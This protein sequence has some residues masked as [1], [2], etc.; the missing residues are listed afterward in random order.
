MKKLVLLFLCMSLAVQGQIVSED[1]SFNHGGCSIKATFSKPA[2]AGPFTTL[3]LVPGSGQND[4][5]GT[6]AMSGGN[7]E[8]LYPD[9]NGK[10]ITPYKD[11]AESLSAAGYAVLRYDELTISCPGFAGAFSYENVFLPAMSGLDYL[12]T[13]N[14]IDTNHLILMGHSEGS[15]LIPYMHSQRT[16]VKALISLA[17]ARTPFDSI[18]AHQLVDIPRRCNGDTTT[19]NMQAAQVL[20]YF[21]M[22]RNG[23]YTASTPD[24]GGL[25]P[26]EWETY[27]H[28]N[29]SVGIL[30]EQANVPTLFIGLEKDINVPL[31]E[32]HRFQNELTTPK[33]DFYELPG[34]IHYMVP[35][36]TER[37]APVVGDTIVYWLSQQVLGA[38]EVHVKDI[39]AKVYPNPVKDIL[40]IEWPHMEDTLFVEVT[41]FSG[42]QV[43][44]RKITK[45]E[46]STLEIRF[47]NWPNGVY[48]VKLKSG[49][50]EGSYKVMK[51]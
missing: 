46:T 27:I 22:A 9:L 44:F 25:K 30:Y 7:V 4:R 15:A 51:E 2:G 20:M 47:Q 49:E 21:N 33:T 32:L 8:C 6:L 43:F 1:V 11:L 3:L 48:A 19:A 31:S 41:D 12:K 17:G 39:K 13:R 35:S 50:K 36:D 26:A 40:T 14:D 38:T 10:T 37:V 5:N 16:D 18:L 28:I 23:T 29:D 45:T 42:K 24:F 34:L